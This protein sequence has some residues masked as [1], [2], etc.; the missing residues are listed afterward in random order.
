MKESKY[1]M[2]LVGNKIDLENKEI[3]RT[4]SKFLGCPFFEISSKS[5]E[6]IQEVLSQLVRETNIL[7]QTLKKEIMI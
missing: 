3:R 2:V 1:P 6:N 5:I 7:T 4:L